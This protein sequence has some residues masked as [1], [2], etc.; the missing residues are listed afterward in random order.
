MMNNFEENL[1]VV[2]SPCGFF[3]FRVGGIIIDVGF[4][5]GVGQ[6]NRFPILPI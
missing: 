4:S 3:M 5:V 1:M 6:R 2:F